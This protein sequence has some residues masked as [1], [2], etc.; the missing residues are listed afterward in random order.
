MVDLAQAKADFQ[1]SQD[2]IYNSPHCPV[3]KHRLAD[4]RKAL[5]HMAE[6]LEEVETLRKAVKQ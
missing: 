6:L 5:S 2:P 3:Q 4:Y 1:R